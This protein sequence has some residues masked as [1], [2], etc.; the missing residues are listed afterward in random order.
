[1]MSEVNAM[2][3]TTWFEL[4]FQSKIVVAKK[5][6][7]EGLFSIL[8]TI[9]KKGGKSH[10]RKSNVCLS[11]FWHTMERQVIIRYCKKK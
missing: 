2:T 6:T 4:V 5:F 1:M 7:E 8:I 11:F 3:L 9:L 10:R